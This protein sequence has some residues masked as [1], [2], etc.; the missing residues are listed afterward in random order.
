ME[1]LEATIMG[2]LFIALLLP[3][4]SCQGEWMDGCMDGLAVGMNSEI[5]YH[6]NQWGFLVRQQNKRWEKR[7]LKVLIFSVTIRDHT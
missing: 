6:Q 5:T 7:Y 2:M 3:H 4:N 1:P